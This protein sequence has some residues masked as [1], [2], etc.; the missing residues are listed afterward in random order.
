MVGLGYSFGW[1][2]VD[3]AW[4]YLDYHLRSEGPIKDL[5][6]NGPAVGVHF[7]W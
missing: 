6:F 4:R 1:G 5:N 7:R 3:A 2:D